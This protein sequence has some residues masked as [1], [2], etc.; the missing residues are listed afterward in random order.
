M[1]QTRLGWPQWKWWSCRRIR[2][3]PECKSGQSCSRTWTPPPC[4]YNLWGASV[5]ITL[6]GQPLF[7]VILT[8]CCPWQGSNG[9][10]WCFQKSTRK[11]PW[12]PNPW[13]SNQS[14]WSCRLLFIEVVTNKISNKRSP[15][16]HCL[17][18]ANPGFL[19]HHF[20]AKTHGLTS[21]QLWNEKQ[22][23]KFA[24]RKMWV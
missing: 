12:L 14:R 3:K 18:Y 19:D 4:T 20:C 24:W 22:Y 2:S 8:F 9:H 10:T 11:G 1:H 13:V 21:K 15:N 16:A 17:P 7:S 5:I 6:L 23:S